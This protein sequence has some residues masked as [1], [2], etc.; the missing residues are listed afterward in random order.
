VIKL[1][2][3]QFQNSS[4]PGKNIAVDESTVGFKRRII[5]E[6]YNPKKSTKLGIRLFVLAESDTAYVHSKITN[7]GKLTG[8]ICNLPYSGNRSF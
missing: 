2:E 5:F 8:D 3:E 1:I 4:L 7:Y 6:I